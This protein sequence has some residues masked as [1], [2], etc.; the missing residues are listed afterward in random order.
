MRCLYE[1]LVTGVHDDRLG[2]RPRPQ[3]VFDLVD[4]EERIVH[5]S[6]LLMTELDEACEGNHEPRSELLAVHHRAR[7]HRSRPGAAALDGFGVSVPRG[8]RELGRE[9]IHVTDRLFD[10]PSL[11][12]AKHG[13]VVE[14]EYASHGGFDQQPRVIEA[15]DGIIVDGESGREF[16]GMPRLELLDRPKSKLPACCDDAVVASRLEEHGDATAM[17]GCD[18]AQ[19]GR[20]EVVGMLVRESDMRDAAKVLIRKP[21]RRQERSAVIKGLSLDPRIA[22]QTNPARID[23]KERMIDEL[24]LQAHIPPPFPWLRSLCGTVSETKPLSI[25]CKPWFLWIYSLI[26]TSLILVAQYR[27]SHRD[28]IKPC[29]D[30]SPAAR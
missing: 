4:P 7:K 29:Q 28:S 25:V 10:P 2:C 8:D 9:D 13:A 17:L 12:P 19:V 30:G 11:L 6:V 16:F 21:G 5:V 3:R 18:A 15:L 24:N 23:D 14:V 22:E 1:P 20:I 26:T 27:N